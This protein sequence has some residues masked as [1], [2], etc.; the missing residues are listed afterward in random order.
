MKFGTMSIDTAEGAVLAHSLAVAGQR[1]KKA[2]ILSAHDIEI[3]SAAGVK[4]V[5]AARLE[6]GDLDENR[7]AMELASNLSVRGVD[8]RDAATGRVNIHAAEA[9]IFIVDKKLVDGLNGID[10]ALT[11][12]TL[13]PFERVETGQMVAT[14]KIIPFGVAK[15]VL[16]DA[17]AI[18]RSGE[19]FAVEGFRAARVG[20]IQT[21]LNG[22]KPGVLDKTARV[23][24]ERLA[25]SGSKTVDELRVSHCEGEL[26]EAIGTM[27]SACDVLLI[28]GASA[29]CDPNDVIPAAIR[30]AGGRVERTGMPVD[31]GNLL[32]LGELADM[33]VI[34]APGCARSAKTNGFDWILD[35][36]LAGIEVTAADIA[37]MGVGGLLMEI[38]Q[39]PQPRDQ[40]NRPGRAAVHAAIL[41]AGRSSRMEGPNKLL[42]EFD[43]VPLIRRVADAV[44][45][46]QAERTHLIVGHQRNRIAR[47]VDGLAIDVVDNPDYADGLSTSLK[48]AAHSVSERADGL[49]VVLGDMPGVT[50]RSLNEMIEAFQRSGGAVIVRATHAGKRGNPVILPRALFAEIEKIEG[51]VGA[52]H[53]VEGASLPVVDIELGEAASLDLDTQDAVRQ[54]G[55]RIV[56]EA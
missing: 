36:I 46:S 18:A 13:P 19:V 53:L 45:G 38:P 37:K 40:Q 14:I 21:T 20:L 10:P 2:H 25:R 30:R 4:S 54:A 12:A 15:A 41:A 3:L 8:I 5:V 33:T 42:A 55:G 44:C 6:A 31:P 43:G 50:T 52:R 48:A 11:I 56:E 16:A 35:R 39:R 27:R 9:G 23:T 34:G 26:A 17:V 29:V 49:L 22:V 24:A 51:D 7:A 1:F 32:V 47:T 28:F